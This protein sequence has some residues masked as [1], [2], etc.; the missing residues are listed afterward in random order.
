MPRQLKTQAVKF[1]LA[2]KG[3]EGR[4]TCQQEILQAEGR[5]RPVQQIYCIAVHM[6]LISTHNKHVNLTQ[7][8]NSHQGLFVKLVSLSL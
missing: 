7:V 8:S 2:L 5:K 4:R 6:I 3:R 1:I